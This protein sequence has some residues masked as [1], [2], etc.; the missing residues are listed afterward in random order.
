MG[1]LNE[2]ISELQAALHG[3]AELLATVEVLGE[4]FFLKG[5]H[6]LVARMLRRA[7]ELR[8]GSDRELAGIRH[9]LARSEE[10]LGPRGSAGEPRGGRLRGA[11]PRV[12][13]RFDK[14]GAP[15]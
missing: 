6:E 3:G 9:W 7:I 1:L 10:M 15:A 12:G 8:G 5:E 13:G 4:C 11:A 2:A 14:H